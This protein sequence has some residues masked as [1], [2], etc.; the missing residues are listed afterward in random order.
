MFLLML[1]LKNLERRL[2]ERNDLRGVVFSDRDGVLCNLVPETDPKFA[3]KS[4]RSALSLSEFQIK[5]GCAEAI[6]RLNDAGYD[7][8]VVSNQPELSRGRLSRE[9][10]LKIIE[11]LDWEVKRAGG[12]IKEQ[13]YCPHL[14]EEQCQCRKPM[15]GLFVKV[16][17][18]YE[19]VIRTWVI[20]DKNADILAGKK[21]GAV[22]IQVGNVSSGAEYF[23]KTFPDAVSVILGGRSSS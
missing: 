2:K 10:H 6:R 21:I 19:N 13:L 11:A 3:D 17:S 14:H 22:T 12:R 15:I 9:E 1:L 18:H 16:L 7:F 8:F 5:D 20:G 4:M 23:V